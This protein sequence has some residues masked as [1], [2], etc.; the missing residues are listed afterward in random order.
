MFNRPHRIVE[1][2]VNKLQGADIM[3]V[4][5]IGTSTAI[6]V[7]SRGLMVKDHMVPIHKALEVSLDMEHQVARQDKK[8]NS[9]QIPTQDKILIQDQACRQDQVCHQDPVC[10]RDKGRDQD[11]ECRQDKDIKEDKDI[12]V[13]HVSKVQDL[14]ALQVVSLLDE[15][16]VRVI[17]LVI[18]WLA[19]SHLL[20][21]KSQILMKSQSVQ[22]P[23]LLK[24][25]NTKRKHANK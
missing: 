20:L 12:K 17:L 18:P 21:Q 5:T 14:K 3:S 25:V 8:D 24:L 9:V 19:I 10:H 15:K 4:V 2:M 22:E 7:K 1:P 16:E 13:D 11:L 23:P 6:I